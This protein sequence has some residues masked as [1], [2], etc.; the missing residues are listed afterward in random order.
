LFIQHASGPTFGDAFGMAVGLEDNADATEVLVTAAPGE[1]FVYS[2]LIVNN[3]KLPVRV[4]G[5]IDPLSRTA[6][7]R[8]PGW[9][10]V[11]YHGDTNGGVYPIND[12]EPLEGQSVQPGEYAQLNLTGLAASCATNVEGERGSAVSIDSIEVAYEV[13]GL[14]SVA[15]IEL[16]MPI[17][18]RFKANCVAV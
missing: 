13:V 3:G 6:P 8:F 9:Q 14:P 4:L 16:P 7:V 17:S 15:S 18:E 10:S 11:T 2:L 5:V 12:A 1:S